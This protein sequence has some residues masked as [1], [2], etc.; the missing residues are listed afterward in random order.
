[1]TTNI[2]EIPVRIIPFSVDTN[3]YKPL[4]IPRIDMILAAFNSRRDVYPERAKLQRVLRN[5][6]LKVITRKTIHKQLIQSINKCKIT[7][8][9]NNIFKSLSMRYTETMAC[10]GFLMADRPADMDLVGFEE[11][12]HL[13]IYND[14]KD[15]K[16]K[17]K[18]YM[19]PKNDSERERISKA[20]M[21]HVRKNHSCEVRVKQ[22]TDIIH[23]ELGI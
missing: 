14:I 19:D 10:G 5:M 8:T 15:F 12:K 13:I 6:K 1:M 23:K 16:G 9:S 2:P 11:G 4:N 20:G 17:V 21:D 18:Y 22:M 3:V 7:V